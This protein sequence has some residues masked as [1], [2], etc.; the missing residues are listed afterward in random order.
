MFRL[1][2]G[3]AVVGLLALA[4]AWFAARPGS[5]ALDWQGYRVETTLAVTV[6][7]VAILMVASVAVY[8]IWRWIVRG[9]GLGAARAERRRRGG[10]LALT[11]GMVAVAAGDAAAALRFARQAEVQLDDLPLTML[12]SAQAAQLNGDETAAK[13]YFAAM[14][15]RPEMEFLG[16]RGLMVQATRAGNDATALTIARRAYLLRPGTPWVL[17]A[18]FD[19]E[20]RA[21]HW[22]EAG[23]VVDH[24]V[25]HQ[26]FKA[27][28]ARRRKAITLFEQARRAAAGDKT[29]EAAKLNIEAHGLDGDLVPAAAAAM[30]ALLAQGKRRRAVAMIEQAWA[31]APHPSLGEVHGGIFDGETAERRLQRAEKLA[32]LNPDDAVSRHHLAAAAIA[33]ERWDLARQQLAPLAGNDDA[34]AVVCRLMAG[35]EEAERGPAYARTWLE[36]A[37]VAPAG[38]E[39]VC[40]SCGRGFETWSAHCHHC[41]AFDSLAW[42]HPEAL[43]APSLAAAAPTGVIG[44]AAEPVDDAARQAEALG[45]APHAGKPDGAADGS[46]GRPGSQAAAGG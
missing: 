3:F 2:S 39:W 14:L 11:Q 9:S 42:R 33:A 46:A 21:G 18:L 1:I 6:I 36:R 31:R 35:L 24:A 4:A 5:V 43:A 25:K 27:Q 32:S 44:T 40:K 17:T 20:A 12:L 10:Q 37:A 7:A 19:L 16:L 29:A 34:D 23:R 38:A 13:R 8:R 15:E 22:V 41:D 30:R 26:V 28:E 45:A